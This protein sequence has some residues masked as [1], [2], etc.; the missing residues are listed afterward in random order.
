MSRSIVGKIFVK[1]TLVAETPVAVGGIGGDADADLSLAVDGDGKPYVPGSSLMGPL[2]HWLTDNMSTSGRDHVRCMLGYQKQR[3]GHASYLLLEDAPIGIPEGLGPEIRTSVQIDRVTG[4]AREGFLFNRMM[5]PKGSTIPLE[6]VLD[7]P[8]DSHSVEENGPAFTEEDFRTA[9]RL[10]LE[11]LSGAGVAL[12]AAKSRGLGRVRL[13]KESLEI[14]WYRFTNPPDSTDAPDGSGDVVSFASLFDWLRDA[15]ARKTN[16]SGFKAKSL[17]LEQ[18]GPDKTDNVYL[19]ERDYLN[20]TVHWRP[21]GPVMVKAGYDGAKTDTIPLV[22]GVG[23]G[24]VAPVLTGASQKGVF[25]SHVAR[26][27]RTLLGDQTPPVGGERDPNPD[28]EL[29]MLMDLF[30][31]TAFA[32]RIRTGD[33][34]QAVTDGGI[35]INDWLNE[36]Q[37]TRDNTDYSD[38]VAI[39]RF[40]GGE[41]DKRLYNV[42]T[43]KTEYPWDPIRLEIDLS[44]KVR[45]KKWLDWKR[46]REAAENNGKSADKLEPKGA[47]AYALADDTTL[48]A[49]VALVLLMLRDLA[50]G[51][52]PLGFGTRRG[53]GSIEV[54]GFDIHGRF[55]GFTFNLINVGRVPADLDKEFIKGLQSAWN[56][57]RERGFSVTPK[58][59]APNEQRDEQ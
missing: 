51:M 49:E 8:K 48:K 32:G 39:D 9:L 11:R 21:V 42:R 55:N 28:G 41:V 16:G 20:I 19:Q 26:I 38:H 2:R 46:C 30:G 6:I 12:G 23:R 33:V 58:E 40:T 47:E 5:L 14:R 36:G 17:K 1:G 57:A 56:E 54:T 34:Y 44:R 27:L 24:K 10:L 13:D 29:A 52:V 25:R 15:E 59:E 31:D 3:R 22:S 50:T 35:P 37:N 45:S 7:L 4:T 53:L 18:I 43:P